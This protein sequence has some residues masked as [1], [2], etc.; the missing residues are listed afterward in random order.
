MSEVEKSKKGEDQG[1][2][3]VQ[4]IK[5]AIWVHNALIERYPDV[6]RVL[7]KLW[8]EKNDG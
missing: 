3:R 2:E 8:E 6:Y 4:K 5:K 7:K 1:E